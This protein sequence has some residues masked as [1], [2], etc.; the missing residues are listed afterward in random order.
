MSS[1]GVCV[2]R[3]SR[4]A[5]AL[6]QHPVDLVPGLPSVAGRG[7]GAQGGSELRTFHPVAPGLPARQ[8]LGLAREVV[9]RQLDGLK[10]AAKTPRVDR[11]I[12]LRRRTR[13]G[14]ALKQRDKRT[15]VENVNVRPR[16]GE[17]ALAARP[18]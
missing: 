1:R 2:K 11:V 3:V 4:Q 16:F 18:A 12:G 15:G 6:A 13:D 7:T 5:V 14:P 17:A 9:E 8:A 10:P